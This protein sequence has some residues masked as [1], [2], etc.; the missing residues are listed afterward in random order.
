MTFLGTTPIG[1]SQN[2][3]QL[4]V[5]VG[6]PGAL[7]LTSFALVP[8]VWLFAFAI[9]CALFFQMIGRSSGC[10]KKNNNKA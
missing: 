2:V 4:G 6:I 5:V 9:A 8:V 7:A 10:A 3:Q 1:V